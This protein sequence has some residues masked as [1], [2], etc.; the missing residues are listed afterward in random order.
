MPWAQSPKKMASTNKNTIISEIKKN[1]GKRQFSETLKLIQRLEKETNQEVKGTLKY[2]KGECLIK[3]QEDMQGVEVLEELLEEK[4]DTLDKDIKKTSLRSIAEE[5]SYSNIEKAKLYWQ[6]YFEE[7]IGTGQETDGFLGIDHNYV[8]IKASHLEKIQ[9]KLEAEGK[10]IHPSRQLESWDIPRK[11]SKLFYLHIPKCGGISFIQPVVD[12]QENI[13]HLCRQ[14]NSIQLGKN[15]KLWPSRS[16]T[17]ETECSMINHI[18]KSKFRSLNLDG[19]LISTHG[20]SASWRTIYQTIRQAVNDNIYAVVLT[21][22]PEERLKSSLKWELHK[23][24]HL[25]KILDMIEKTNYFDNVIYKFLM[26]T[27]DIYMSKKK[28]N[29][30][31]AGKPSVEQKQTP[32]IL[33]VDMRDNETLGLIK[34]AYLSSNQ[35]PNIIQNKYLNE[36]KTKIE[37]EE[38]D[39]STL[40][41]RCLEKKYL[42]KDKRIDY[43]SFQEWSKSKIDRQLRQ[44]DASQALYLHPITYDHSQKEFVLTTDILG[45]NHKSV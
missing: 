42:S 8:C 31:I 18:I 40:Y 6:K 33:C 28:L 39:I 38:H 7:D 44:T 22:D 26:G 17:T 10:Q 32:T 21:R 3:V 43:K 2:F 16:V 25:R 13:K 29:E 9:K 30:P 45:L 24:G 23:Q 41:E 37:Q 4:K 5:L 19:Y 34:S 12:L 1:W 35:L 14:N 27:S 20:A 11:W 36:S 15:Y